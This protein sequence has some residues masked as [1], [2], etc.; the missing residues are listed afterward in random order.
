MIAPANFASWQRIFDLRAPSRHDYAVS[1]DGRPQLS[2][3]SYLAHSASCE[4]LDKNAPSKPG[5]NT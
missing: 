1:L 3:R 5:T 4:S 2:W